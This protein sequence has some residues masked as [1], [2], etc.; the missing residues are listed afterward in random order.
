MAAQEAR[1]KKGEFTLDDF[2]KMLGQMKRLGP[3]GKILGMIPGMGGL[4]DMMGDSEAEEGMTRMMGIIDSMTPVEPPQPEPGRRSGA[5][6]APD[7]VPGPG[8]SRTN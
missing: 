1:L 7:R 2:R 8:S 6:A 3:M 5:A 4:A